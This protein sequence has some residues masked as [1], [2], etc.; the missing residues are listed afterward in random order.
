MKKLTTLEDIQSAAG[1]IR[2]VAV[3]TPVLDV[4]HATSDLSHPHPRLHLKCEML[5]AI[6]AFKIR[7]AYNMIAQMSPEERRRGLLA[8]SSG[9]HG[10]A[11]AMAAA[12]FN[13]PA[14]IVMPTNAPAAKINGVLRYGAE[15][16]YEG[17]TS[18]ERRLRGEAIA[19]AHGMTIIPPFD[20]PA[21]IA[22]QGTVGLELLEQCPDMS[23]V[24]VPIGGGGLISGIATAVKL[25]KPSTHVVGVEPGGA[26]SMSAALAAGRPIRIDNVTSMADGLL[27]ERAGEVTFP[28]V[29]KFVDE[30]MT[31]SEIEIAQAVLWLFERTRLVVEPSGAV[32]VAAFFKR[33]GL[34]LAPAPR[35]ARSRQIIDRDEVAVLSGGNVD[36][37][38]LHKLS[39]MVAATASSE[40]HAGIEGTSI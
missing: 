23:T 16:V 18:A 8:S 39:L 21:I 15:I 17:T 4:S 25:T 9:N 20:H 13:V 12:A 30:V 6:G 29:E 32:T 3:R 10:Q 38:L 26:A 19:H 11:T 34:P 14:L 31:V 1:R 36:L 22:G 24:Y 40:G 5:Q 27:A 7:G 33:N 35:E 2:N 37:A 28:H